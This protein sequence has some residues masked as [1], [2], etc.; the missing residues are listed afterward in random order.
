MTPRQ[1]RQSAFAGRSRIQAGTLSEILKLLQAARERIRAQLAAQPSDFARWRLPLLD[2][3]IAAVL[4]E[5]RRDG[6]AALERGAQTAW[7]AG[8]AL[9]DEPLQAA[10]L[11]AVL[12]MLDTRQLSAMQVFLV[13]RIRD[14]TAKTG[15]Q[16]SAELGLVIAGVQSPSEAIAKVARLLGADG[17]AAA[18]ARTIVRTELGRA[19]SAA[20][21]QR[22]LQAQEKVPGLKKQWRRSGKLH[23]RPG[24]DAIDGEVR[25]VDEPFEVISPQGEVVQLM[26]PRDPAGPPGETIN[27]GCEILPWNDDWNRRV[28][29]PFSERELSPRELA[30]NPVKAAYVAAQQAA[31]TPGTPA[32]P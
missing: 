19:F 6:A 28:K 25:A 17:E 16:I 21:H 10:R 26:Y 12:P 31:L 1:A 27:C 15:R 11:S 20:A 7:A 5:L 4:E 9:V 32:I 23:S 8:Q 18:R 13:D 30:R 2:A 29:A 22:L 14:I 24:H 3:Q